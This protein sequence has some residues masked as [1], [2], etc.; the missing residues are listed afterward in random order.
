MGVKY[1]RQKR[2]DA[3]ENL[4]KA[5]RVIANAS[6]LSVEIYDRFGNKI[7][8]AGTDFVG[9]DGKVEER[10]NEWLEIDRIEKLGLTLV[11]EALKGI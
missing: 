4:V 5:D 9:W 10:N 8:E 1:I 11:V 6:I 3:V 7:Y 2:P